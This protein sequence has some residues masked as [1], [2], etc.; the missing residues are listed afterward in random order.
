[1]GEFPGVGD[2]IEWNFWRLNCVD[3]VVC[4]FSIYHIFI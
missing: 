3:A 2:T 4:V 1:M